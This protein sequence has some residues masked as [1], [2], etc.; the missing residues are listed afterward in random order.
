MSITPNVPPNAP[1]SS[2]E[3]YVYE[4]SP[5]P[6]WIPLVIVVLFLGIGALAYV[7]YSSRT[8]LQYALG[9]S[10]SHADVLSKELEQTNS[11]L[12]SVRAQLDVTSQKLGLTQ[13]ELARAR[14][15]AQQI[16]QEQEDSDAKLVAQIGQ[17]QKE[18]ETKIGQVSTDLT[19]A[20][21]DIAATRKDLDDTKKNLT[22]AVG[23]LNNQGVLIAR[24]GEELEVLKHL[25]DRNIYDFKITKS[26][27]PQRVGPVQILLHS[28]DPKK[29]KFDMTVIADD[30]SI[31]KKDRNVDEP[32]QFYVRGIR[33][34]YELV[35]ME[36]T[37]NGVNGYLS[38]PKETG[39]PGPSGAAS[40]GGAA[41]PT[42]APV[43]APANA[44]AAASTP[45][46]STAPA[47]A[48]PRS[49]Q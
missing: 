14:G 47:G 12:A 36:V 7:G 22:T 33:A 10:N 45:A 46:A 24:N 44:P 25:N 48:P 11:R 49:Q 26:K 17:V 19:G 37:K 30:K 21:S 2:S 41:A 40:S 35:V 20:K 13:A 18:N 1:P 38:T 6:R 43:A 5:T 29:Y 32:M 9:Q 34:P 4:P 3:T 8:Q 23:D 42:S 31:D 16:Q 28:T 27:Q 15:M 39:G